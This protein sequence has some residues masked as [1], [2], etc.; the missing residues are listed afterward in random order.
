MKR[1]A[2]I[3]LTGAA[4]FAGCSSNDSNPSSEPQASAMPG[5]STQPEVLT[6]NHVYEWE[7]FGDAGDNAATASTPGVPI[8]IAGRY[9]IPVSDGQLDMTE[10]IQIYDNSGQRIASD[11]HTEQQLASGDSERWEHGLAF[12]TGSWDTGSYTAEV[13]IRDNA[14][15]QVSEPAEVEFE[16]RPQLPTANISVERVDAPATVS[17][18]EPYQPRVVFSNDG[19]RDGGFISTFSA[20][21]SISQ[22]QTFRTPVALTIPRGG[23]NDYEFGSVTF[24]QTGELRL[25]IDRLDYSWTVTVTD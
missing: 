21:D 22:W 2:F 12:Q 6:A 4:V 7:T 17:T 8:M 3:S 24:D 10:Q 18:G 1:R 16:M 9:R 11:S 20:R 19:G 14:T 13:L 5:Q 23:T 25:R 15:D